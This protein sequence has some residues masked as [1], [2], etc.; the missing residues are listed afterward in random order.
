MTLFIRV[1]IRV[2]NVLWVIVYTSMLLGGRF[3]RQSHW[4]SDIKV[5]Q[6]YQVGQEFLREMPR[7]KCGGIDEGISCTLSLLGQNTSV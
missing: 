5:G 7:I 1:F 2:K 4:M 3:A 6:V